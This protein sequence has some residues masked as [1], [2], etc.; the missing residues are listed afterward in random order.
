MSL[1]N[2][3]KNIMKNLIAGI[4]LVFA[5]VGLALAQTQTPP[6][7][8]P[9]TAGSVKQLEQDWADAAKAG[10]TGKVSQILADDWIGVGFDGSKETKQNHLADMKSGKFKVESFEF[11]PMDVKVL[12]NVAVVQGTKTQKRN[13]TGGK[14]TN[15][16]KC[17]A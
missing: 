15:G 11:G 12:V 7:K 1:S 16:K 13:G 10:D 2:R 4:L 5:C 9:S 14:K 8:G 3:R 17:R 6:A